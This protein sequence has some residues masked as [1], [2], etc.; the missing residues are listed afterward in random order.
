MF[1]KSTL[2]TCIFTFVVILCFPTALIFAAKDTFIIGKQDDTA[3]LDPAK[4]YEQGSWGI[5][6][7]VYEKLVNFRGDD[8]TQVVP[9]L[10]ESWELGNDGKT[11]TFHL[12]EGIRFSTGNPVNADA[13]VFSLRRA[14]KLA[15]NS[16]WVLT[17]FGITEESITK[18]DEYTV[19]IGLAHQYAP[20]LFLSC[21]TPPV[22]SILDPKVVMGHEQH[23][24]MGSFW[25]EEHS[26]GTGPFV[27]DQ[28]KRGEFYGLTT[29][30]YYWKDK[31]AFQH[32]L[33]KHIA[34]PIE[35]MVMLEQGEID[36]AWNLL[37]DQMDILIDNPDVQIYQSLA[38]IL[39][40]LAMNLGYPPLEKSEVRDAIRY[41]IDYD[42]LINYILQGAGDKI[43]TFIPKGLPGYNPAMLYN[44]DLERAK[45]LLAKA[46]YPDGFDV[47]LKCANYSPWLE[48]AMKIKSDLA[49]IGITVKIRPITGAQLM[50]EA[51]SSARDF[52]TY[53]WEWGFDYP[54]PDAIAKPFAHC[55][56]LG[57][58]ATIQAMAWWCNYLNLETSRLVEQ[59]AREL[60]SEKRNG[61]YKQITD[62]ILDDGPLA[63]FYAQ[64][65]LYGVRS[66]VSDSIKSPSMIW[67]PFPQLK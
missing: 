28:Q 24:D 20:G 40:Y 53:I 45:H 26:A 41:A 33:V 34:E 44:R 27:L 39:T 11:W 48:M 15:S 32:I 36:L 64:I 49:E 31:P 29:N 2:D 67:I 37:P 21:L 58:D 17:Q 66:A 14:V 30:E 12:R 35:Q 3:S 22:A 63:I 65:H 25:L 38:F 57:E 54:D 10:A 6:S 61:L 56:S 42:G 43:Q 52:Q 5:L 51:W 9:E 47:E 4:A 7:Q 46:D 23:G 50:E 60:D 18:V 16:S 19:Q 1:K 59:A 55:D 8:Y 13:V 62:I